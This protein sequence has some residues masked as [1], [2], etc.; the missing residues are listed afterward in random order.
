MVVEVFLCVCVCHTMTYIFYTAKIL[1]TYA[2]QPHPPL[3]H[4]TV[5]LKHKLPETWTTNY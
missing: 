5:Q 3:D 1:S 2:P 4:G